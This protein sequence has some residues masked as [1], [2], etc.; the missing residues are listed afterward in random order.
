M[1]KSIIGFVL[2]IVVMLVIGVVMLS[3]T[4]A[5]ARDAHGDPIFFIKRQSMW[6]GLGLVACGVMACV[7]Y[8]LLQKHWKWLFALAAVLLAGCFLF[9]KINGAQRWIRLGA[10]SLQPSELGKIASVVFLATW[11]TERAEK[12]R[13]FLNGFVFPLACLGILMGLIAIEV[14]LGTTSLIGATAL[15]VMFV[16]G[17]H[18]AYLMLLAIGGLSGLAVIAISMPQRLDRLMA[19][20][21]IEKHRAGS[22]YQQFEALIALVSG[23]VWGLGLGN[24]R[25][26][27]QFLP[28]AH[29]D[30]IFPMIGEELGMVTTLVI[31]LAY[32]AMIICG[33]SISMNA[34]D[35]FGSL[36]AFGLVVMMAIQAALN[37]G[38]TTA[39]L[40]N[41]GIALPFISYGGSSLLFSLMGIGI[42]INIYRQGV[43]EHT[44]KT[45]VRI[46]TR[47]TPRI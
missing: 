8:H 42:V 16:A 28:E 13:E 5:F 3:S 14:D 36:L 6:L 33:I 1:K 43:S 9:P 24:G 31:V 26:K 21:D 18:L 38:V 45:T 7:D 25:Q 35:R 39:L 20:M 47:I 30:F 44:V 32:I 2:S 12:S 23:G 11:F 17:T 10:F 15:L 34:R 40:P 19:F 27:M 46:P 22:G 29:T 41:K 37:I 4:G